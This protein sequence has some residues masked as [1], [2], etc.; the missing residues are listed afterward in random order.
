[1]NEAAMR[2]GK[3]LVTKLWNAAKLIVPAHRSPSSSTDDLP[4]PTL[5]NLRHLRNLRTLS[6]ADHALLSQ[7]NALV[8]AVTTRWESYDYAT[9]LELTERF[10]WDV[11]CDEYLELIKGRLYDGAPDERSAARSTAQAALHTLLHLFAPV[12]PHITE[13]IHQQCFA[14][15]GE[16]IHTAPWPEPD[17][18]LHNPD[19]EAAGAA[20]SAIMGAV[21]RHKS[22]AGLSLATPLPLLRI[23]AAD[24]ALRSALEQSAAALRS[25]TRA[26]LLEL[27]AEPDAHSYELQPGLWLAFLES[28]L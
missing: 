1:V 8:S 12:L 28:A 3:R 15:T 24:P 11:F 22:A 23:A 27:T 16:S 17:S 10:F 19:A 5:H 21:R 7:L 2:Q 4:A 13:A 14:I 6:P 26:E 25:V 20:I 9:A 18:A